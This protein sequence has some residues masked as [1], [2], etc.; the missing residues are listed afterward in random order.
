MTPNE[1]SKP[2]NSTQVHENLYQ[3]SSSC[4]KKQVLKVGDSVR[5][6]KYK[7]VFSKGYLPNFTDEIFEIYQVINSNPKTYKLK[8][9]NDEKIVG[10]FYFEELVKVILQ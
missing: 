2:K 8:D 5:I 7:T 4:I 6:S 1:A 3:D 9:E 10:S